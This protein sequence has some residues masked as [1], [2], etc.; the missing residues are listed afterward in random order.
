M[1]LKTEDV[2]LG[3]L[4]ADV[5]RPWWHRLRHTL[6]L[7]RA[8]LFTVMARGWSSLA[9]LVTVGLIAHFLT[10]PE[11]GYYYTFG[12]LVALQIVFELGFSFVILQMASHESAHL[13]FGPDGGIVG[14]AAA[15]GRLASVLQKSVRWYSV[16]AVLMFCTLIPAGLYFFSHHQQAGPVVAW[17]L[18]WFLVVLM[19]SFAFQIDPLFSFMEGCGYVPRVARARLW[20]ALLGSVLAWL[21]L[22]TH[23]GLFA[24]A[25]AIAGQVIA[26]FSWLWTQRR[27]LLAL[28][29]HEAE[30]HRVAWRTEVW[31]F[32]WRIAVSWMCGYFIFQLF[33][34]VLF[35]YWGPLAA[36]QMGMSLS[37]INVLTSVAIAWVNTKAALFGN[38]IARK[39]YGRLDTIFFRVLAQSLA[40]STACSLIAWTAVKMLNLHHLKVAGRMLAP[41]PFGLFLI[42]MVVNH[43][44]FSEAIYLRSHKQEKLLAQSVI[45]AVCVGLSTYVLGGHY[46][47]IGMVS[48]YLTISVA[49]LGFATYTFLHFRRVWHGGGDSC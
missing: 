34:P 23:H 43:I 19:A 33:V 47:A 29:R 37:I 38:L 25:M 6:G 27:L 36:G 5:D 2:K 3:H 41:V 39:E 9:G 18:P 17:R 49:G 24:P 35:A 40:V 44:V 31:P 26:G 21:A 14:S 16:A 10:G 11:Q 12:S 7:D 15:H 22:L 32:Q 13:T 20:Q 48:G 45:G 4:E 46:G 28:F 1:T 8:I 42:A 30:I